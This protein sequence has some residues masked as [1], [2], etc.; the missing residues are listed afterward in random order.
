MDKFQFIPLFFIDRISGDSHKSWSD[1]RSQRFSPPVLSL[2]IEYVLDFTYQSLVCLELL[3][4]H[5]TRYGLKF[6]FPNWICVLIS[7]LFVK[8]NPFLL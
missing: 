4:M 5:G 1:P 7:I 6:V 2:D 8:K 3:L